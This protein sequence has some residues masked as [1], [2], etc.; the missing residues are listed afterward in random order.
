MLLLEASAASVDAGDPIA[1]A[2]TLEEAVATADNAPEII[3][4]RADE[5]AAAAAIRVART[6][7]DLELSMTTNT[8]TARESASVLVPLPW[9]ARRP[10]IAAATARLL[11]AGRSRE[12]ALAT[13]RQVLR[14]AWFTLAAAQQ[15]VAAATDRETRA[16]RNAEAVTALFTEG[17]VARLEQ[18]RSDAEAAL[19]VSDRTSAEEGRRTAASIL[20]TLMGLP[21]GA[22]VT[23][24]GP[25][26]VPE[27]ETSIEDAVARARESSPE[28]RIQEAATE[29]A[30]AELRLARRLRVPSFALNVGADWN[31]PTQEGTNTF[32]G[33]SLAIPF[34]GSAAVGV[35]VGERDRQVA[36]LEQARRV[37]AVAAE[38]AWG[39]TRAARLRFEAIDHDV[40]PAAR[41]AAD[42]TRLAYH[43]GKVD[44]FRLLDA[45]RL[46]S[47]AEAARAD[48]YE[49]WGTAHADLLRATAQDGP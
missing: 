3:A 38:I 6:I 39:A 31:D 34:A 41:Q 40:L 5:V 35:A 25:L 19:A 23:A 26:P 29:A 16:R 12:E 48:A 1:R 21:P 20:A 36:L 14:A 4:A 33:V 10:R 47:E 7:P 24:S 32:A 45:E 15:R 42:L 28:V 49:A 2:V 22:V 11:T 8:V 13:A 9:P 27:P 30:A 43:E 44:I 18:V 46:L 17:R 37:A